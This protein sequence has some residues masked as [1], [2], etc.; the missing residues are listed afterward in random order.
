MSDEEI[1]QMDKEMEKDGSTELFQQAMDAQSGGQ[2]SGGEQPQ[3][4]DNTYEN[5]TSESETPQLDAETDKY[6]LG[7]NKK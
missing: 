7:I 4:V 1:Q 5:G 6:S 3:P 2:Q